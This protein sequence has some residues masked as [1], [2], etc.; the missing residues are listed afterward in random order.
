MFLG[1][2]ARQNSLLRHGTNIYVKLYTPTIITTRTTLRNNTTS[3]HLVIVPKRFVRVTNIFRLVKHV[4]RHQRNRTIPYGTSTCVRSTTN[5]HYTM[6]ANTTTTLL[7]MSQT[8]LN[9]VLPSIMI[10]RARLATYNT[11]NN[12]FPKTGPRVKSLNRLPA[13]QRRRAR[14]QRL[15]THTL[16]YRNSVATTYTIGN[17]VGKRH[18]PV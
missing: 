4:K 12:N 15:D 14:L 8:I 9:G 1:H 18:L 2:G 7:Q 10:P 13:R 11:I 17:G 5:S 6:R 16:P 3:G